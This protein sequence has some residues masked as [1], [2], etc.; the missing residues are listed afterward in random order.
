MDPSLTVGVVPRISDLFTLIQLEH[1][2]CP[3][4]RFSLI[5]EAGKG[6]VWLELTGPSGTK[7]FSHLLLNKDAA[8]LAVASGWFCA[9]DP[10]ATATGSVPDDF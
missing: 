10:V 2:C 9:A 7:N 3:F 6:P 4:L 1:Q 8:P 5:F